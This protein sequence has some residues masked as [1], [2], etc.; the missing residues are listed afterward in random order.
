MLVI[1]SCDKEVK[2]RKEDTSLALENM[3]LAAESL[4]LGSCWIGY[5]HRL[6]Y[7][8]DVLAELGIP[9]NQEITGI[10]IFGYPDEEKET[11]E[12][13]AKVLKWLE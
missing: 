2:W 8:P 13:K 11:P 1:I 4:G 3:F 6:N 7:F 10:A 12:R 5:A 9:E